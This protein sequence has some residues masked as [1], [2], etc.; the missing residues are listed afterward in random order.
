M[1]S[2]SRSILAAAAA[3]TALLA[4][5]LTAAAQTD[6]VVVA[7]ADAREVAPGSSFRL[8][9]GST[10]RIRGTDLHVT[11]DRVVEDSRCPVNVL[12]VWAGEVT[13]ELGIRTGDGP[14][15]THTLVLPGGGGAPQNVGPLGIREAWVTP[16]RDPAQPLQPYVLRL[17]LDLT[18]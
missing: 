4:V 15:Q 17:R 18:E 14:E 5:P 9:L 7:Q 1:P 13:L 6:P 16:P 8:A 2:T 3:L 12:C 10:V 11:F